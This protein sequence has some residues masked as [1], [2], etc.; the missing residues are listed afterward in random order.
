ML[1]L[2]YMFNTESFEDRLSGGKSNSLGA[3][4]EIVD[5][6]TNDRYLL[7][8]LFQCFFSNN[9]LVRLRTSHAIK[10]IAEKKPRILRRY[11]NRLINNVS[12][13]KQDAV[14]RVL[15]ETF[16]ILD[17][18]LNREQ[19]KRATKA[20]KRNLKKAKREEAKLQLMETLNEWAQDNEE[21]AEWLKETLKDF[22]DDRSE[23]V[24][25]KAK[26]IR[27]ELA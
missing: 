9:S 14:Q 19:K 22:I 7:E 24:I 15:A 3:V 21:L 17:S 5:E 13:I 6:V 26:K 8:D 23:K 11:T 25:E 4:P 20:L 12:T 18:E 27:E 1:K 16:L 2:Q 10:I